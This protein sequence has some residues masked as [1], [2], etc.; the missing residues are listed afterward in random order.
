MKPITL[1]V[2]FLTAASALV[3]CNLFTSKQGTTA[4]PLLGKWKLDSIASK[5]D[6]SSMGYLLLAMSINDSAAYDFQFDKDTIIFFGKSETEKIPYIYN[7]TIKH[8]I[9]SNEVKDTFL[10]KRLNDSIT[11]FQGRDSGIIFLKR[12]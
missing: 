2:L 9:T 11:G 5:D 7:D 4:N 3:S 8:L 1:A 10:V 12:K 6:S